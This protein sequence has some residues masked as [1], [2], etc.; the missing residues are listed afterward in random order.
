MKE[1]FDYTNINGV[2]NS[3]LLILLAHFIADFVFQTRQMAENKGKSTYWLLQHIKVYTI[4]LTIILIPM[5]L[6]ICELIIFITINGFLHYATD[7]ST[8]RLTGYFFKKAE[9]AKMTIDEPLRMKWMGYFW[10]TIGFD[11][12]IHGYCLFLTFKFLIMNGLAADLQ[13]HISALPLIAQIL[14]VLIFLA[15]FIWAVESFIK[16][17]LNMFGIS[18]KKEKETDLKTNTEL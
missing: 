2:I 17:I 7:F 13:K 5:L 9:T 1:F 11:Q 18:F 4:V 6:T 16:L 10:L 15:M 8:S 14:I 3:T 12:L